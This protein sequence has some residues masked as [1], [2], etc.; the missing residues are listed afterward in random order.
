MSDAI[1]SLSSTELNPTPVPMIDLVEQYEAIRDE[2]R[3]TVDQ[4]LETQHFVLGDQVADF[5]REF[6]SYIDTRH[7]IGCGSGTDALI[8]ALRALDIGP[9]DEVITSP[10]SFFATGS[11]I[12]LVGATPVFVD[13]DP[14]NFNICPD[15]VAAAVTARTKAI[16]PVHLFGQCADMQPLWRI[17]VRHNLALVEDAAQAIGARYQGRHAGV[18]G[19]IGCFSFFPTKNLGGA[20][21]GGMLSTDDPD[22]AARLRR[23]RVHGDI[24]R[25]EHVEVGINSRLDALQAAVLRVK[26][27]HLDSWSQLRRDNAARYEQLFEEHGLR[28]HFELPQAAPHCEHVYNQYVA[29]VRNGRRDDLLAGLRERQVGCAVY[30]PQPI[31]LQSC[32]AHLGHRPGAFPEAERASAETI[33]LPIYPE[34]GAERQQL[35]VRAIADVLQVA[36]GAR[37]ASLRFPNSDKRAA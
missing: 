33:A 3:A 13:I 8:L 35:V 10:Y 12:H 19:T 15:A 2:V 25:Y 4:V 11:S 9:G 5:E 27:R 29:R 24:G 7:A 16:V 20:G 32:F 36:A 6:E 22:L 34:L 26:L 1:L 18:L 14:Q 21:D 23:L 28:E 30:Y 17:A 31:H 37:Q